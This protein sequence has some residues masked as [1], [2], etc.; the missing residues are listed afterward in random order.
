M[1]M[2]LSNFFRELGKG[3][4]DN[5]IAALLMLGGSVMIGWAVKHFAVVWGLDPRAA[6]VIA[7]VF[8]LLVAIALSLLLKPKSKPIDAP[9][10]SP[11]PQTQTQTQTVNVN[12]NTGERPHET[13][14]APEPVPRPCFNVTVPVTSKAG[15]V[16]MD[17]NLLRMA[18]PDEAGVL[19]PIL[20]E[21]ENL[22]SGKGK[23][24]EVKDVWAHITYRDFDFLNVELARVGSG[25]WIDEPIPD[26]SFP[27][28]MPRYLMLG[29]WHVDKAEPMVNE[30]R[31]FDY[32]R[33]LHRAVE[34]DVKIAGPKEPFVKVNG[35]IGIAQRRIVVNVVLTSNGNHDDSCEYQFH[36]TIFG[37]DGTG[38]SIA[39]VKKP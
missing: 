27:I 34:K 21:F 9:A 32:S 31:I 22:P 12:V 35:Q 5:T 4:A 30:F 39:C 23:S 16:R 15:L 19:F 38:H 26:V 29:G 25:C 17:V 37:G 6:V 33:D 24:A 7:W 13:S 11:P 8:A 2:A 14:T 18:K 36:L 10:S 28:R 3:V 20:A 1:V